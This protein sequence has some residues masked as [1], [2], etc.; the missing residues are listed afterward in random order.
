[1]SE[2]TDVSV[3]INDINT[4][5]NKRVG[6]DDIK[7][8]VLLKLLN[9]I[10]VNLGKEKIDDITQFVDISRK[11]IANP[12]NILSLEAMEKEI[13]PLYNKTACGYYKKNAKGFVFNCVRVMVK[14]IGGQIECKKS[15]ISTIVDGDRF[16]KVST[17][18]SIK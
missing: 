1:M 5:D 10:L 13:F 6:K 14:T 7:Y 18:Y 8:I 11:D 17:I 2:Q 16:V 9:A 3:A 4:V 15:K 12:V